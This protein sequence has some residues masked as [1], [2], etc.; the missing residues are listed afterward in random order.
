MKIYKM[1]VRILEC[2]GG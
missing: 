2:Y 1:S